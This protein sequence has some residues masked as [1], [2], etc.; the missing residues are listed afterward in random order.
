MGLVLEDDADIKLPEQ[1]SAIQTVLSDLPPDWDFC[2]LGG[3]ISPDE[4]WNKVKVKNN[5]YTHGNGKNSCFHHAHAYLLSKK[6]AT[7]L[8]E[9]SASFN[10]EIKQSSWNDILPLDDWMS[11]TDRKLKIYIVQP[12]L[13]WIDWTDYKTNINDN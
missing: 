7:L 12:H 11:Q 2:Y 5:I 8:L 1:Y 3:H 10:R 6:G 13:V 9:Q 4:S